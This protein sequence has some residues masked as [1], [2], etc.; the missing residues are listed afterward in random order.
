MSDSQRVAGYKSDLLVVGSGN[1]CL[2]TSC[3][4]HIPEHLAVEN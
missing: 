1:N 3:V 4:L 2:V